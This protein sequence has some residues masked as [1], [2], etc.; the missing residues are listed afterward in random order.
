VEPGGGSF[1]GTFWEK[2]KIRMW[3]PL[4]RTQRKLK[5]MSVGQLE[6]WKGTR[7]YW[8]DVRVWGTKGPFI[9]PRCIGTIRVR[10]Q[11]L[12]NQSINPAVL[13]IIEPRL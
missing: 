7:L 4:S 2:N 13:I 5:A 3:V 8:A 11:M 12:I 6:I 1:T 10:A 9:R